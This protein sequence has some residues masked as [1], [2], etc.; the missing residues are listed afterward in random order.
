M[1]L[2]ADI[3]EFDDTYILSSKPPACLLVQFEKPCGLAYEGL[4]HNVQP[5]FLQ[6]SS[7]PIHDL[8]TNQLSNVSR[9]QIPCTPAFAITDYKS[10]GHTFEDL[11]VCLGFGKRA[12]KDAHYRWTS[13]NVQLGRLTS[14]RGLVLR[15]PIT[16]RDVSFCPDPLLH[17][18][19]E[20]LSRWS[21]ETGER[22]DVEL[23]RE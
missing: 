9:I 15:A 18:E 23:A 19:E 8:I 21:I 10:Q 2:I 17:E 13:L 16:R 12:G 14:F 1:S 5:I 3:Y 22:W 4:P 7:G 11:E 20:K 6:T